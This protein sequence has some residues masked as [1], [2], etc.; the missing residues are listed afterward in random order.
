MFPWSDLTR[1]RVYLCRRRRLR[2]LLLRR[3]RHRVELL[4][5]LTPVFLGLLVKRPHG[6]GGG[7]YIQRHFLPPTRVRR[8]HRRNANDPV[9]RRRTDQFLRDLLHI[10]PVL[11]LIDRRLVGHVRRT[12][13]GEI[14]RHPRL[15]SVCSNSA[16]IRSAGVNVFCCHLFANRPALSGIDCLLSSRHSLAIALL[17]IAQ[18]GPHLSRLVCLLAFSGNRL[19]S[20][21]SPSHEAS[22]GLAEYA[23][24]AQLRRGSS[25]GWAAECSRCGQPDNAARDRATRRLGRSRPAVG[26]DEQPDSRRLWIEGRARRPMPPC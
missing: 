4:H 5:E 21:A 17:L 7:P 3:L 12:L 24:T 22:S 20:W 1:E 26:D 8:Q 11:K 2:S 6:P 16:T 15:L 19:R 14:P 13:Q 9:Q 10:H 25:G 18:P 23:K